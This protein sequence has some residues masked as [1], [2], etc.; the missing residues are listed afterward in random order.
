MAATIG[1]GTDRSSS[2]DAEAEGGSEINHFQR[3]GGQ[4]EDKTE[5]ETT[6]LLSFPVVFQPPSEAAE[7]PNRVMGGGVGQWS[8]GK[9]WAELNDWRKAPCGVSSL[10]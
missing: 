8:V 1:I 10:N 9:V 5:K 7:F 3:E 6:N 2:N 4:V